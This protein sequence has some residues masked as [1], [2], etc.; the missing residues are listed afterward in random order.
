VRELENV[1]ERVLAMH[2]GDAIAAESL[3]DFVRRG[4]P[5]FEIPAREIP[6]IPPGGLK[7]EEIVDDFEKQIILKALQA[8]GGR[9]PEAAKLLGLTA[10]SFRYRLDKY[11]L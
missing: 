3:P 5:P 9:R 4:P 11:G 2:P 6:E 8:T 7:I 1:V 10:R